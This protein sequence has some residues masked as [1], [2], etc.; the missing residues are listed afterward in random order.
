MKQTLITEQK[1][2]EE[3]KKAIIE[4]LRS[5][6]DAIKPESS[7]IKD[8]GAESLD[9]LDINYR[10]EQTFGIK[11]ARHFILEHIEE[12]FGE[13]SAIDENGQLTEKAITLLKLRYGDV[14]G[15]LSEGVD[16]DAVPTL[17]T[18]GSMTQ[19]VLDLLDTLPDKCMQCGNADWKT[20]DGIR[21]K[22]GSCNAFATFTNG[23]D[24]SK[25]WLTAV[26]QEKKIF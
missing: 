21:I 14:Y 12:M 26:Q 11:M 19:G 8:L 7:L 2:F 18:A 17:I 6:E 24:L 9:F 20:E 5:D 4:T 1:V 22:C 15:D 16:M 25:D 23:D 3:L 13:G 10:L